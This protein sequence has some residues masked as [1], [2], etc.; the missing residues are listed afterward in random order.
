VE[1]DPDQLVRSV[2]ECLEDAALQLGD[3]ISRIVTAGMATQRSNI[4]CWDKDNGDALSPVISWQDTRGRGQLEDL[5]SGVVD[6]HERT[7]LF[8]SAHYGAT[9][10]RWCLDNIAE[11]RKALKNGKLCLGPMSSYL[12]W[13][14][15]RE[16]ALVSDPVSAS[17]TLLWNIHTR[18]WDRQLLDLFGIPF[19]ALP[20]CVPTRYP[21]GHLQIKD[22]D[23]P[24]NLVT[25]D[26][27]AA[28][29][30]HGKLLSDTVYVNIGTGAFVSRPTGSRPLLI[31][32]LLTGVVHEEKGES[33]Y[34]VE[35]TVNGAGS[36][37]E[38][39]EE[40]L[41]VKELWDNIE[42]WLTEIDDPPLF[43][44]GVSGLGAPYW[45]P[46]FGSEFIGEGTVAEKFVAVVESI[47]F[48]IIANVAEMEKT[49]GPAGK[50]LITG[51]LSR[52]DGLCRSLACLAGIPV[53]RPTES[54]ATAKGTGYLL[55]G[56]P[57]EWPQ[58][59]TGDWFQP[60]ENAT[61]MARFGRWMGAME[62]RLK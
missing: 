40:T 24:L 44:N 10:L 58:T 50:I 4:V 11:V 34:V 32:R 39:M 46:D 18:S 37:L 9:K 47:G 8:P 23:V 3:D 52:L 56:M 48:L 41:G 51:G 36:A 19:D 6:F 2:H 45:V 42:F 29:F 22:L 38:W 25:G 57:E 26:Q 49:M 60:M 1:H 62:K 5:E 59:G 27:S 21:F 20:V 43:L 7:G 55:A 35:G 15:T 31:P 14:L 28:L 54:E 53:H 16:K 30:A 13:C 12:V 33:L 61:L 17:R